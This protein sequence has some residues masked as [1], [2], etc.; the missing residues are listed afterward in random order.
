MTGHQTHPDHQH[1]HGDACGHGRLRHGGHTDYLH[2][3]HLHHLH[4]GHADEHRL[5]DA[6]LLDRPV[7]HTEVSHAHTH[8]AGCGHVSVPHA[9]HTDYLVEGRLHQAH[10]D[11]CDD[12]G[13]V[14]VA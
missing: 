13:A 14:P 10:G 3:G 7:G 5:A 6:D 11:H 2:E 9:D 12:H 4:E 1:Q 8:R